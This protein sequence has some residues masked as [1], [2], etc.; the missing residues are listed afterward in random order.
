MVM[1]IGEKDRKKKH[2][3]SVMKRAHRTRDSCEFRLFIYSIIMKM[4]VQ[5]F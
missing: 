4:M 1:K 5:I 2:R 3:T